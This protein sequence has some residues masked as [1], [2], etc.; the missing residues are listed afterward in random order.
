[1]SARHTPGELQVALDAASIVVRGI[2]NPVVFSP[3]WFADGELIGKTE[4]ENADVE[5][6]SQEIASFRMGWLRFTATRDTLQLGTE[7]VEEL[8]RLRDAAIGVLKILTH[9][10]ISVLGINR[11]THT[12]VDSPEALNRLGDT[13]TP[14]G[15][16]TDFLD[17]PGMRSV[18]MW[19]ARSDT[20]KGRVNVRVEPSVAF[21]VAAFVSVNDHF[22]LVKEEGDRTDRTDSYGSGD[23]LVDAQIDKRQ[24]AIDILL[25]E[26]DAS[27]ARASAAQAQL[28]ALAKETSDA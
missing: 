15:V 22:E 6:I 2:F 13:I 10:P 21:P 19:G 26:W 12:L 17:T 14:K 4:L 23:T 18:T 5:V 1:M 3:A 8:P 27:L 9:H 7:E 20:W 16:W 25:T 24:T 28:L 11:D